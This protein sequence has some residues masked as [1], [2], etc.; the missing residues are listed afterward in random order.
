VADNVAAA[1]EEKVYATTRTEFNE[2]R[3]HYPDQ[4]DGDGLENSRYV[5]YNVLEKRWASGTQ[6]RTAE[7]D[8]STTPYPVAT[9]PDGKVYYEERGF[10]G[11]GSALTRSCRTGF[12]YVAEGARVMSVRRLWPN[13]DDRQGA[14]SLTLYGRMEP[15][16]EETTYGPYS[17][18]AGQTVI[19]L[20]TEAGLPTAAMFA[21]KWSST[22][23]PAFWRLGKITMNGVIRGRGL[24]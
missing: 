9:S 1:Q 22:T 23:A 5:S 13:F 8:Q 24:R 12:F 20:G 10:S 17:V 21:I 19:D 11:N 18:P 16:G 6:A 14:I 3:W 4:R 7:I 2:I 15:D